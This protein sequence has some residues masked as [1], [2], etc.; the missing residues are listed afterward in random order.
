MVINIPTEFTI[1][2]SLWY[3]GLGAYHS[4]LL[5]P[6]GKMCCIGFFAKACGLEDSDILHKKV[7]GPNS[8]D[9]DTECVETGWRELEV[10]LN[11]QEGLDIHHKF[12]LSNLY[13][14]NDSSITSDAT[15]EKIITD[16]FASQG[17]TVKFED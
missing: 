6:D 12:K 10:A 11:N 7:L 3:R 14:T 8:T 17:I 1:K 15:K 5:N 9:V 4:A 13:S 2:R 16:S